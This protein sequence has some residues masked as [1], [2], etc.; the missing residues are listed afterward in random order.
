MTTLLTWSRPVLPRPWGSAVCPARCTPH[1]PTAAVGGTKA[2]PHSRSFINA[3]TNSVSQSPCVYF[4]F[5]GTEIMGHHPHRGQE[6]QRRWQ[7]SPFT[8]LRLFSPQAFRLQGSFA[9]EHPQKPGARARART[10]P[11]VPRAVPLSLPSYYPSAPRLHKA[12]NFP[13]LENNCTLMK[14]ER[15]LFKVGLPGPAGEVCAQARCVRAAPTSCRHLHKAGDPHLM[16]N[17]LLG[18]SEPSTDRQ[19][20]LV[21]SLRPPC[22]TPLPACSPC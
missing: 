10:R 22:S 14:G 16:V 1:R 8:P 7:A 15:S 18:R 3:G 12:A 21:T 20:H 19:P 5:H 9:S 17:S 6:A 13:N 2:S 11:A 4:L